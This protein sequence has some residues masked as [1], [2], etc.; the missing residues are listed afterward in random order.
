MFQKCIEFQM[1]KIS[2][3]NSKTI[4]PGYTH[5]QIAQPITYGHYLLAHCEVLQRDHDRVLNSYTNV[6]LSPLGSCAISGTGFPIDRNRTS[7]LL[8]FNKILENIS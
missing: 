6:D 8:G 4:M 7:S 3:D 2:I 1:S 5:T